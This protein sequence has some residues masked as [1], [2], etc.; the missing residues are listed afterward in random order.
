M[1]VTEFQSQILDAEADGGTEVVVADK[2][3][4]PYEVNSIYYDEELDR[5]VVEFR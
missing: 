1:D 4:T 3:G 5:I 2:R